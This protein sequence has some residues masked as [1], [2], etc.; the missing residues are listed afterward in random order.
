MFIE[1]EREDVLNLYFKKLLRINQRK[2]TYLI[3]K[4]ADTSI[5]TKFET[6]VPS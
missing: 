5:K 3:V 6:K 4:D 2:Y 1:G